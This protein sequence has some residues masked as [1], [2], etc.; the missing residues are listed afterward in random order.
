MTKIR[1]ND[2]LCSKSLGI[3]YGYGEYVKRTAL[4]YTLRVKKISTTWVC[5]SDDGGKIK[6]LAVAKHSQKDLSSI[7]IVSNSKNDVDPISPAASFYLYPD[8][9]TILVR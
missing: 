5:K 6:V 3:I 7:K 1:P 8:S 2:G 4:R 9:A